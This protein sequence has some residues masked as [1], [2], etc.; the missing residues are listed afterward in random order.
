MTLCER[1]LGGRWIPTTVGERLLWVKGQTLCRQTIRRFFE[2]KGTGG[3]ERSEEHREKEREEKICL[4]LQKNS[5]EERAEMG[6][7]CLSK[8]PFA[9]VHRLHG[10]IAAIEPWDGQG[11]A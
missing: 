10:D 8:V 11:T 7:A 3:R 1:G 9:P 6:R 4:R 2:I 5:W